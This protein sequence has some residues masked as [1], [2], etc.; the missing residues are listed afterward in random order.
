[1]ASPFTEAVVALVKA[2]PLG[3]VTSYGAIAAAAGS[4]RGARQVVRVLHTQSRK[5]GLPWHRVV[6]AEGRVSI[7]DPRG[8]ALQKKRLVEEG[9]EFNTR[10]RID[11]DRFM[12]DPRPKRELE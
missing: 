12:W 5:H 3:R 2:V 8:A 11:L 1:M 4:P 10:E 9:V 7:K 6:S